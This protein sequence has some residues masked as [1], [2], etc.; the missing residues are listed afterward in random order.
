MRIINIVA[1]ILC[2]SLFLFIIIAYSVF[3]FGQ[4]LI[5][6]EE[7]FIRAMIISSL[8]ILS[9]WIM[10]VALRR[11]FCGKLKINKEVVTANVLETRS[12]IGFLEKDYSVH[13]TTTDR[14]YAEEI[15][16]DKNLYSI[17]KKGNVVKIQL[18]TRRRGERRPKYSFLG[19]PIAIIS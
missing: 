7:P 16:V 1:N 15:A 17:L 8:A 10:F 12:R 13:L 6:G 5:V 19:K 3:L 2:F 18:E 11:I 14:R 4:I 9:P